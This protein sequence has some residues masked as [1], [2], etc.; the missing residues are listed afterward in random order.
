M[1][2]RF[3]AEYAGYRLS[4]KKNSWSKKQVQPD[5]VIAVVATLLTI[6]LFFIY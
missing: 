2:A 1:N 6:C 3:K 5:L 4:V